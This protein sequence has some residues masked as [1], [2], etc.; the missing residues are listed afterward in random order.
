MHVVSLLPRSN[1]LRALCVQY[2]AKARYICYKLTANQDDLKQKILGF[3]ET[4]FL[5]FPQKLP[6]E[7]QNIVQLFYS[8]TL[9]LFARSRE[10]KQPEDIKSCVMY[11]RYLRQQWHNVPLKIDEA[12]N[13]TQIL[14]IALGTQVLLKLGDVAQ[15]VEEMADLC[16]DLLNSDI[17][18]KALPQIIKVLASVVDGHNEG[19]L[20]GLLLSEKAIG[21]LRKAIIRLPDDADFTHSFMRLGSQS[22]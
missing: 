10:S 22:I 12:P 18:T 9:A 20:D 4:I 3:T 21:C 5:P 17:P 6:P 8:L 1:P 15:D 11:L 7:A 13:I 2:L 14:V 19:P 16:D